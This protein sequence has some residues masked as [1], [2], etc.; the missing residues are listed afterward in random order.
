MIDEINDKTQMQESNNAQGMKGESWENMESP[1]N[2]GFTSVVM[3]A[4]KDKDGNITDCAEGFV[5]FMGGNRSFPVMGIM[6]DR[7]HRLKEMESGDT[8]MYRTKDDKQQFHLTKDGGFWSAPEDKTVRMQLVKKDHQQQQ[9]GAKAGT[10]ATN[11]SGGQSGQQQQ[12]QKEK[13]QKPV[14]KDS[15]HRFVDVTQN[16]TNVSG[17]NTYMKLEDGKGYLHCSSDKKVWVGAEKGKAPFAKLLTENGPAVNSYGALSPPSLLL[18][19]DGNPLPRYPIPPDQMPPETPDAPPPD[20]EFPPP[21]SPDRC[22]YTETTWHDAHTNADAWNDFHGNHG[23]WI[24]QYTPEPFKFFRSNA[25]GDI[26]QFPRQGSL[27]LNAADGILFWLN[28][29]GGLAQANLNYIANIPGLLA[30]RQITGISMYGTPGDTSI[31]FDP[32]TRAVLVFVWGGSAGAG[33]DD[34]SNGGNGDS[35]AFDGVVAYGGTAANISN[36]DIPNVA[37]SHGSGAGGLVIAGGG[38]SAP[39]GSLGGNGGLTIGWVN[40]VGWGG[41]GIHVAYPGAAGV[42]GGHVGSPGGVFVLEMT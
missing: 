30:L 5:S 25:S 24:D 9:Q 10:Q 2:Y 26:P 7:R 14:R 1:Q 3:P 22:F 16:A 15:T 42:P 36:P 32:R 41:A 39:P 6:D 17:T 29:A 33:L 27:G 23:A 8:A 11:G 18:G 20:P 12:G 19:P 31:T 4:D 21:V 28:A 35:S 13:G 37:G 38:A 40:V 34:S